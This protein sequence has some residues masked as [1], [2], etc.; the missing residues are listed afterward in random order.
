MTGKGH[1]PIAPSPIDICRGRAKSE[2]IICLTT[3]KQLQI[4]GL[5]RKTVRSKQ[6]R[7]A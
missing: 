6:A 4:V 7:L 5:K 2:P 1:S 3:L